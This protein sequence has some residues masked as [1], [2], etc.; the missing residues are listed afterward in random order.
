MGKGLA[1]LGV[2]GVMGRPKAFSPLDVP[3]LAL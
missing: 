2:P 3:G 1:I